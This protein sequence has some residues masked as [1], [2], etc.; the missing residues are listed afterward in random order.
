MW[1]IAGIALGM[2]VVG[3]VA[4][5][6]DVQLAPGKTIEYTFSGTPPSLAD[7]MRK[8]GATSVQ[9]AFKLPDTYT[10][11]RKF[12]LLVF[13]SGGDGGNGCELH[14]ATPLLGNTDYIVCN[15]PLFKR[16][17]EG[18]TMD[19]QLS[20]T[21]LDAEYAIP[22]LKMLLDELHRLIPNIDDSHSVL[23]G[24]S[25]GANT[26]ALVL[27]SGDR[28]LLSRFAMY[29]LVEGG[30]WLASDRPDPSSRI[31]FQPASLSTLAGKRVLVAFGDQTEPSDRPPWIKS[32]RD[33]VAALKKAGVEAAEMPM[34]DTGHDFSAEG[35]LR[36]RAWVLAAP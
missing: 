25:N 4:P 11:D 20:I 2:A 36:A 23:G 27:W 9:M 35:M 30:F 32:A 34:T 3:G 15:M 12:P 33:T 6:A 16:D 26:A 28:E 29:I 14:Q 31:R 10:P 21:P 19:E 18:E 1:K 8:T 7:L 5:A 22:A 17:I 24:F 13:L